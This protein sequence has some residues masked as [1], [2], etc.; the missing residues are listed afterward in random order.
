MSSTLHSNSAW[1][2]MDRMDALIVLLTVCKHWKNILLTTTTLWARVVASPETMGDAELMTTWLKRSG[3]SPLDLLFIAHDSA[4]ADV[5]LDIVLR[6]K[7]HWRDVTINWSYRPTLSP[8]LVSSF[9]TAPIPLLLK[10]ALFTEFDHEHA[11]EDSGVATQLMTLLGSAPNLRVLRW[12][13]EQALFEGRPVRL[14]GYGLNQLRKLHLTCTISILECAHIMRQTPLLEVCFFGSVEDHEDGEPPIDAIVLPKLSDF[15]LIADKKLSSFF[16]AL[17]L[18]SLKSL[19]IE[20][21]HNGYQYPLHEWP[22]AS[23]M[24]FLAR[25]ACT[26]SHLSLNV[27]IAEDDLVTCLDHLS[28]TLKYL[29]LEAKWDWPAFGN[30]TLALLTEPAPSQHG[31]RERKFPELETITFHCSLRNVAPHAL[32]DMIE[33]RWCFPEDE[34]QFANPEIAVYGFHAIS[35]EDRRRIRVMVLRG[36]SGKIFGI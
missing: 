1:V 4:I 34:M 35:D 25:S 12:D 36:R 23:F 33:S 10:F 2:K 3:R 15:T 16:R 13:A 21:R 26:L 7:S 6:H 18:P 19:A 14:Q 22:Q 11:E 31:T 17:R 28:P 5:G 30:S 32:A 8:R 9:H 20:Y 24:S 27:P 29:W